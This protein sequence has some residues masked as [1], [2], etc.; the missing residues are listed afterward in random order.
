[1]IRWLVEKFK[2]LDT[3]CYLHGDADVDCCT[4]GA[5]AAAAFARAVAAAFAC[6]V[7]AAFARAVAAVV[8]QLPAQCCWWLN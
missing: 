6:A 7:A 2:V 5:F 3:C 1:M 4:A 8:S